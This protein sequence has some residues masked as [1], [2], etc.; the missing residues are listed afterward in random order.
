MSE[1]EP[2]SRSGWRRETT[3]PNAPSFAL[4]PQV[5]GLDHVE[6]SRSLVIPETDPS[7]AVRGETYKTT[8]QNF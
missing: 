3:Q 5:K 7:G 2:E 6:D 4:A 1:S 8:T